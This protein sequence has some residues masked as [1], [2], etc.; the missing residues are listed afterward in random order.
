MSL[1]CVPLDVEDTLSCYR[2]VVER[3]PHCLQVLHHSR[4]LGLQLLAFTQLGESSANR[5]NN[6][7]AIPQQLL[8]KGQCVLCLHFYPGFSTQAK[9]CQS[10]NLS[11]STS[12]V[13]FSPVVK[14]TPKVQPCDL[15]EEDYSSSD[16]LYRFPISTDHMSAVV[17]AYSN[18]ISKIT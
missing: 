12:L 6:M 16:A 1:I 10:R 3:T 15:M 2:E 14:L 9:H 18:S 8:Q 13:N 4:S 17:A 5:H 11:L 7:Q